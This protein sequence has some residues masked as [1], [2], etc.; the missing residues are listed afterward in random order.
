MSDTDKALESAAAEMMKSVGR[1]FAR[2]QEAVAPL[3]KKAAVKDHKSVIR[4]K[5]ESMRQAAAEWLKVVRAAV[6]PSRLKAGEPD[7][8]VEALA[9]WMAI[10]EEGRKI[11]GRVVLEI[12][13][14]AGLTLSARQ[15]AAVLKKGRTDPIGQAAVKWARKNTARLVTRVTASTKAG[16]RSLIA[17]GIASGRPID[18]TAK[19]LRGAVGLTDLQSKAALNV[20]ERAIE[21]GFDDADAMSEMDRY[22]NR[23]LRYREELI[24]TTETAA[25][26]S[27]GLL[28]AYEENGIESAEWAADLG[29]GCCEICTELDGQVFPLEDASGML[30]AHPGCECAWVYSSG[31]GR[32]SE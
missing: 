13:Q 7:A 24:A 2:F 32:N 26:S 31:P 5:R 15:R 30:P 8:A 27:E 29:P 18:E 19:L 20:Y 1:S 14:A 23:A 25:A 4:A 16:I 21:A 12:I 11:Y 3:W 10:E 17:S 6:D 9:D 28:S 22:S